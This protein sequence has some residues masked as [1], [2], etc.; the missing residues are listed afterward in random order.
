MATAEIGDSPDL[1]SAIPEI[2]LPI[3]DIAPKYTNNV[4]GVLPEGGIGFK[5]IK[6]RAKRSERIAN[7]PKFGPVPID[8]SLG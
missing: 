7:G 6:A 3:D 4:Y 8:K 5:E 2:L 1:F